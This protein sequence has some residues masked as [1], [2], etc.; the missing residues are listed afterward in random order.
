MASTAVMEKIFPLMYGN[1]KL[2]ILLCI[3]LA[4]ILFFIILNLYLWSMRFAMGRTAIGFYL[5]SWGMLL[6]AGCIV[7]LGIF[8]RK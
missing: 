8:V 3:S 5:W 7:I 4:Y 2:R 1:K 6:V